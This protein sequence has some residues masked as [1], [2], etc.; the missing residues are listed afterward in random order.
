MYEGQRRRWLLGKRVYVLGCLL[1][2]EISVLASA[3]GREAGV[4]IFRCPLIRPRKGIW[5]SAGFFI[6]TAISPLCLFLEIFETKIL[7]L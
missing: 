6:P 7:G 4:M 3:R 2:A 5:G 1:Y